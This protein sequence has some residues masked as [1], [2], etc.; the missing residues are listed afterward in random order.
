LNF[1]FRQLRVFTEVARQGN[2]TRAGESLHLTA[3]AVSMQIK[4]I[5]SQVGLPLFDRQGRQVNL[6]TAGEYGWGGAATGGASS[7][8]QAASSVAAE[9]PAAP[10]RTV[11]LVVGWDIR[12]PPRRRRSTSGTIGLCELKEG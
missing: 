12:V 9:M 7:E 4:E 2:M 3:P 11:R 8:P 6:S 10:A 5:E 1:T